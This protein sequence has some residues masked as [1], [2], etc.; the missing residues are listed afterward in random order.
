MH[1][2]NLAKPAL[3]DCTFEEQG[4]SHSYRFLQPATEVEPVP[5]QDIH[6]Q[7][8]HPH[9]P[10]LYPLHH[11]NTKFSSAST[12]FRHSQWNTM[13]SNTRRSHSWYLASP[14]HKRVE[15]HPDP[16]TIR[17][18]SNLSSKDQETVDY[19]HSSQQ[20]TGKTAMVLRRRLT[21]PAPK[22]DIQ[23]E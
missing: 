5:G 1:N 3:C 2:P 11:Q 17:Q 10:I 22:L 19:S 6:R 18:P 20:Q 9:H 21:A 16:N 8:P 7:V 12:Q 15:I 23:R 14:L 13:P 4:I